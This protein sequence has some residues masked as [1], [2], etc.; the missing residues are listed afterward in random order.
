MGLLVCVIEIDDG[1]LAHATHLGADFVINA[2]TG[3]PGAAI[4]KAT[5]VGAHDVLITAPSLNAIKQGVER[6]ESSGF[7]ADDGDL[8]RQ[9]E[10]ASADEVGGRAA[11]ARPYGQRILQ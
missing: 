10:H 11:D 1:K 7:A 5:G 4:K 8:E 2:K 9:P 3:D 6:V